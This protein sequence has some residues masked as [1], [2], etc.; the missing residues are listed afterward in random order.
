MA[1]IRKRRGKWVVDYRDGA[2]IRHWKTCET[3]REAEDFLSKKLPE[4]RQWSKPAVDAGIRFEAYSQRWETMIA[5]TVKP[6]TLAS[7]KQLLKLHLLPTFR[8]VKLQHLQK[9]Q[10][11]AFLADKLAA[12]F[13]R[14]TVRLLHSTLRAMLRAAVDDG[15]LVS[16]PAEKLGR[17]L[18]LVTPKATRQ[19]EIKAMSRSQRQLFLAH[20]Q[21]E[22][23]YAPLFHTMAGTGLR[24]GEA[25]ALQWNDLDLEG[26]KIRVARAFSAGALDT[27]KSGHG[28]TVDISQRLADAL[29]RLQVQ[30]KTEKLK[31]GWAEM[32][33]WVVCTREGA[34]LDDSG[35]RKAM[36]RVLTA[37]KLPPH[38]SPHCL[39]HTYAS[40]MLQQGE[41]VAYVQRQLG[42]AS[43][44]LTVD[45][46][47]KWLPLENQ[48]A[49]DRLDGES[50]SKVVAKAAGEGTKAAEPIEKSGG[51]CRDRTCGPLIKSQLLYQLS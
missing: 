9:G 8:T 45:T 5:A 23:R 11:K 46:Y 37:A 22:A 28:R 16:N 14:N 27:P 12:D 2:G 1:C 21:E 42:H 19:E 15:V 35:V 18:H 33:P 48:G 30:R 7:Y 39:R 17:H 38:F 24:L 51:P 3:R 40:L 43:I 13:S 50:G 41:S 29:S 4:T 6:R 47:G 10:I 44:Q 49:V 20:A 36:A 25:L 26:R 31:R 32:P 34:P